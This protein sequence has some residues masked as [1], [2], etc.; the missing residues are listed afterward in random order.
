MG[1]VKLSLWV[2]AVNCRTSF[3]LFLKLHSCS[4]GLMW[5]L[6]PSFDSDV[7]STNST[8]TGSSS[9]NK[10]CPTPSLQSTEVSSSRSVSGGGDACV[11]MVSA[12]GWY[13][14]LNVYCSPFQRPWR[15]RAWPWTVW[16]RRKR[17][18]NWWEEAC[19]MTSGATSVSLN[20]CLRAVGHK[21]FQRWW[22]AIDE[23]VVFLQYVLQNWWVCVRPQDLE[24]PHIV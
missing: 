22:Y 14:F 16:G 18:T 13:V 2:K 17:P 19:A 1:L 15:W 6:S 23:A 21:L 4:L 8:E 12:H 20:M 5:F 3:I 24:M 9:A 7:T 10:S 11:E